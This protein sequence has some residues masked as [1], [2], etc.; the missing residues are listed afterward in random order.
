MWRAATEQD[1]GWVERF[2]FDHVQ[3][4][5]FLLINLRDHGLGSDAPYGLH[6]WVLE[7]LLFSTV[8]SLFL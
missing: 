6:L 4:S 8:N 3:S 7:S 1:L 5:M 2:L